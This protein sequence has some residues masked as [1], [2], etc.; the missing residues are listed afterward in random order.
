MAEHLLYVVYQSWLPL[1]HHLKNKQKQKKTLSY[2]IIVRHLCSIVGNTAAWWLA[3]PLHSKKVA[4]PCVFECEWLSVCL[5]LCDPMVIWRL[6][7][8]V[9]LP[10]PYDSWNGLQQTPTTK[11]FSVRSKVRLTNHVFCK[12]MLCVCKQPVLLILWFVCFC[13]DF[14]QNFWFLCLFCMLVLSLA[15]FLLRTSVISQSVPD[16]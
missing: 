13:T 4:G 12:K 10:S 14:Q 2:L 11:F 7:Q 8:G 9:N 3:L 5:S 1:S 6:V 16:L 15:R